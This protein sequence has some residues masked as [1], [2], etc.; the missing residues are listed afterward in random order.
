MKLSLRWIFDHIEG[1]WQAHRI[2]EIIALFNK[3]TAEIEHWHN[4]TW[5]VDTFF[6]ADASSYNHNSLFVPE[7]K[8]QFQISDPRSDHATAKQQNTETAYLIKISDGKATWATLRDFGTDRDGYLPLLDGRDLF[9]HTSWRKHFEANDIIIDVDNKSITHRPDMWGH[10]GFAREI[11]A[12]LKLPFKS[13]EKFL[14]KVPVAVT[15]TIS[16]PTSSM[17][18]TIENRALK[19]CKRFTGLYFS[20]IDNRPCNLHVASR[21]LKIGS[22]PINGLVDLTNYITHDWSQPVH[23][24]DAQC[25]RDNKIII[26]HAH[27]EES[28]VS[29]DGHTFKLTSNDVVIA[30]AQKPMCLAGV[31]GGLHDGVSASTS[32]IFFEAACFDATSVRLAALRHKTRTDSSARFEKTLDANQA[33]E[34]IERFIKLLDQYAI[35]Y[36]HNGSITSVGQTASPIVLKIEHSFLEQR[37][38]LQLTTQHVSEILSRLEFKVELNAQQPITYHI[39]VPTF[40]SSKD[41]T[42]KE[43]ILEEVV[44]CVGFDKIPFT[45]PS[46]QRTPFSLQNVQRLRAIKQYLAS[47]C[48][49]MEQQNYSLYDETFL[50]QLSLEEP[51]IV[52]ILNPVS[53]DYSRLINSLIPGLCKNLID[54]HLHHQTL[55]FFEWGKTWSKKESTVSE[56]RSLAGV[57]YTKKQTTDFYQI[58]ERIEGLLKMSHINTTAIHWEKLTNPEKPWY[59]PYQTA[60]I[61]VH[62]QPIGLL[63]K[64]NIAFL[65]KLDIH[66]ENDACFF[67]LDGDW[68]LTHAAEEKKY[69]PISRYPE[70]FFDVSVYTPRTTSCASLLNKLSSITTRQ[71]IP[72]SE[73]TNLIRHVSLYDF[74]ENDKKPDVR[75]FTFRIWVGYDER[76]LE[77]HEI[78]AVRD[79]VIDNLKTAGAELRV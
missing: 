1:D 29:L 54:N 65:Q 6:C 3:T 64:A 38:G 62:N 78:D 26:R 36:K 18:Y 23:A 27:P 50:R 24:Y 32:S 35:S 79:L 47:A 43:D 69:I 11:A 72:T 34:A 28:L 40:R 73:N 59:R 55:N 30:D 8:Q 9:A 5:N 20:H 7:L 33:T 51:T 77:K 74:F 37:S 71:H 52:T 56:H 39:T 42:I 66:P 68:L 10:R 76:T 75:S 48:S 13:S 46:L 58:K 70:T 21:L 45:L 57:F 16:T 67:E 14:S 12:F 60:R 4:I 22:R 25:I 63:G 31:K 17:P 44:R 61:L 19:A 2:D 41:I 53:E 49:M 15:D